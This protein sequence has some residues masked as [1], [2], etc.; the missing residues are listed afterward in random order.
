MPFVIAIEGFR[1]YSG[2]TDPVDANSIDPRTRLGPVHLRVADLQRS[3]DFYEEAIGLRGEADGATLALSAGKEPLVVLHELAGAPPQ[4]RGHSGLYHYAI[5]TPSRKALG[6]ALL[7]LAKAG[8]RLQGASDHLVSEA[9][10]LA[11][12]DGNGIEIYRDRPREEWTFTQGEVDMA[13]DP[14]DLQSLLD[15]AD[16]E[17][18]PMDPETIIGHVH[19]HVGDLEAAYDFYHGTLGFDPMLRFGP[20]ALFLSA[21]GY[22]HHLGVNVWAGLGAPPAPK[23]AAGLEHFTVVMPDEESLEKLAQK[24]GQTGDRLRLA[25]PSGNTVVVTT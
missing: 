12:P 18:G 23:N 13:T 19:L 6:T 22:H 17:A 2:Q 25:D 16:A 24:V 3:K 21:G 10:Y 20:S 1:R 11:D 14:L 4:P 15:E 7:R 5:L 9:L 8:K